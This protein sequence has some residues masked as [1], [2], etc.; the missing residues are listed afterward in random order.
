LNIIHGGITIQKDIDGRES[1]EA[2][3]EF[4]SK[5]DVDKALARDRKEIQHRYVLNGRIRKVSASDYFAVCTQWNPSD[6]NHPL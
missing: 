4:A 1:G 6:L 3:V 5:D 2:F